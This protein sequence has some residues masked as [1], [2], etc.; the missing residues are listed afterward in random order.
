MDKTL[1]LHWDG[2]TW[3]QVT[4]P[5]PGST[6]NELYGVRA[7]SA[8]RCLGGRRLRHR[9]HRQD[10][11]PALGRRSLDT[12]RQPQPRDRR[13]A[14]GRRR[15]LVHRRVGGRRQLHRQRG[16]DADPALERQQVGPGASPNRGTGDELFGVRGTSSTDTWAVGVAV[17]GGVDQ[18]LALHWNGHTWTRVTTPDPGGPSVS[19]DLVGVAG[20][21]A[22]D[23]WAVGVTA[24]AQRRGQGHHQDQHPDP[25]LG[26]LC[27]DPRA[28][29]QRGGQLPVVRG[30]RLLRQQHLGSRNLQRWHN[31]PRIRRPLLLTAPIMPRQRHRTQTGK[32]P[33]NAATTDN[34]TTRR[35]SRR[36]VDNGSGRC[37][38]LPGGCAGGDHSRGGRSAVRCVD[39]RGSS[40]RTRAGPTRTTFCWSVAVLS[41]CNAWAVG[42][43]DPAQ[44]LIVHW[45]GASWTQVPE[46]GP[47]DRRPALFGVNALSAS[48]VWAVGEYFDGSAFRT[49]IVHWNGSAWTQVPSPNVHGATQN[50]LKA[51]RGTSAANVWAVGYFHN[52]SNVDQTLILHWNGTSWKRVPSPDPSGPALD[53]ELT[54]VSGDSAQDA[55][56]VGFY[57][58]GSLDKSMILHWNGTSWK[59][60]TSPNPGSQGT[61]LSGCA[62]HLA[63]QRVG[64][65][66][67]LQRHGGQDPDRALGRLGLEAGEITEPGRF[68]AE[69][70]PQFHRRHLRDRRMG[71]GRVRHRHRHADSCPALGRVG[72]DAGDYPEPW[73]F[74]D[75]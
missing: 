17:I 72:L 27:M 13:P 48:N 9:H 24:P 62:R 16:Q 64:G 37:R 14:V 70:R 74:F 66:L 71:G 73:R 51:V 40:P 22:S 8:H 15:H 38:S 60:V 3:T 33:D 50:V 52:G 65:G 58:T 23:T 41:P 56:A 12:G 68:R 39:R 4:S 28:Q 59:Q 34:P 57:F 5:N 67:Q 1:I 44:T 32:E 61:F 36:L 49:L 10:P 46:P 29:P 42:D 20:T 47:R 35:G 2:H 63:G 55:W 19:S 45:D 53:Q 6:D 54:G 31:G 11:D 21:S 7:V 75:R 43:Y 25:A 18:T 69:Q 26:R 30:G